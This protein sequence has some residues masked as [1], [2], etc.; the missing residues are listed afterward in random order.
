MKEGSIERVAV[1]GAGIMG[2]GIGLE[3]ARFGYQVSLYNTKES[4]SKKAMEQ[5]SEALD[6]MAQTISLLESVNYPKIDQYRNSYDEM[7]R[8][9]NPD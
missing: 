1:I 6:L 7:L 8:M 4:T 3:F 9:V 2:L 5:A